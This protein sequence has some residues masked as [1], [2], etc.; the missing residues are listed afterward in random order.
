MA[1]LSS[2]CPLM[3]SMVAPRILF[4][5]RQEYACLPSL[6]STKFTEVIALGSSSY[7]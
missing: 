3:F 5:S 7:N 4:L 6:F 1:L 2:H